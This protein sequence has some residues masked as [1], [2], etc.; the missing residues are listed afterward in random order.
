MWWET[1]LASPLAAL[2][3]AALLLRLLG[4][5]ADR[6]TPWRSSSDVPWGLR[7]LLITC[8][9]FFSALIVL[10]GL[11]LSLLHPDAVDQ[12]LPVTWASLIQVAAQAFGLVLV[13]GCAWR[14]R[15]SGLRGALSELGLARG[16][17]L[18]AL[19][20]GLLAFAA[21]LPLV[22]GLFGVWSALWTAASGAPLPTQETLE[23]VRAVE[24]PLG[25]AFVHFAAGIFAPV[26]E[27]LVWRGFVQPVCV[28][29]L[30]PLRG[31]ALCALLFVVLGHGPEVYLPLYGFALLLGWLSWRTGRLLAPIALHAALN[32]STLFLPALLDAA[33]S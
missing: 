3:L 8:C 25:R 32:L 7:D 20:L 18:R 33:S 31:V 21:A 23:R 14:G 10:Q 24:D 30:G 15:A 28:R 12:K 5:A 1:L 26:A 13:F 4:L 17:D 22:Q 16:G 27:E 9:A 11:A 19:L 2:A 29:A 6:L